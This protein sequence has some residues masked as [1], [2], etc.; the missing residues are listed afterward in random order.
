MTLN[1]TEK[2]D[3]LARVQLFR[4]VEREALERIA[5]RAGEVD[6]PAGHH[7]V[8][9]GQIGNGLYLLVDGHAKVVRGDAELAEFGPGDFFGELAVL[10]QQPRLASVIA[11]GPVTC[12]ALASWDLLS[13]LEREPVVARNLLLELTARLRE[14]NEQHHH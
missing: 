8:I 9:Q 5:E 3:W 13:L 4:G 10:D 11:E 6:F 7:I 12:L 14:L 2:A 1:V